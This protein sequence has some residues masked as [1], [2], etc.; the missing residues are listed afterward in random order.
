MALKITSGDLILRRAG[1]MTTLSAAPRCNF[2]VT[3]DRKARQ[4]MK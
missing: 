1:G 4:L 3:F 2:A